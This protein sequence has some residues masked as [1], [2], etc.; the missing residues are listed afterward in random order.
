MQDETRW[1]SAL[2]GL[3]R[4]FAHSLSNRGAALSGLAQVLGHSPEVPEPMREALADE[5]GRLDRLVSLFRLLP[6]SS[7]VA[8]R[9]GDLLTDVV[10]LHR[11]DPEMLELEYDVGTDGDPLP[12]FGDPGVLARAMLMLLWAVARGAPTGARLRL[13]VS[14]DEEWNWID[15]RLTPRGD[16]APDDG[17][18]REARGMLQEGG[19]ETSGSDPAAE[20]G[21]LR[22]GI[23]TLAR[24]RRQE[25][26]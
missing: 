12:V 18:L 4:G 8:V 13:G 11:L 1:S 24:T 26:S 6:T 14:G 10:A 25:T 23:A 17:V 15:L 7:P 3:L 9:P 20:P 19:F 16:A 5:A 22:V 21:A 2:E